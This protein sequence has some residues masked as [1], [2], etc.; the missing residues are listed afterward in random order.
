MHVILLMICNSFT[1]PYLLIILVGEFL[2]QD[3]A[4]SEEGAI[5]I[6]LLQRFYKYSPT[7][8]SLRASI[9]V[10]QCWAGKIKNMMK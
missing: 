7:L 9:G 2:K 6:R 8:T 4:L 1:R 3:H 5:N 10:A